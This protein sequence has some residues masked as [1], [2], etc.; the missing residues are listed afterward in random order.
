MWFIYNEC[1]WPSDTHFAEQLF[2]SCDASR[3]EA[4]RCVV[5]DLAWHQDDLL[6]RGRVPRRF[7]ATKIVFGQSEASD[8]T[9]QRLGARDLRLTEVRFIQNDREIAWLSRIKVDTPAVDH[10]AAWSDVVRAESGRVQE[11]VFD[12]QYRYTR[13]QS[14]GTPGAPEC[15]VLVLADMTWTFHPAE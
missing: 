13:R 14:S 8:F 12:T 9:T 11:T 15:R 7:A 5:R 4:D 10:L 1:V 2:C 3:A 6:A